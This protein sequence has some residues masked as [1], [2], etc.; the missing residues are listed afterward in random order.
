MERAKL[1]E[2]SALWPC[3]PTQPLFHYVG[4]HPSVT[5][6]RRGARGD[7]DWGGRL[8]VPA[9]VHGGKR[10]WQLTIPVMIIPLIHIDRTKPRSCT[11]VMVARFEFYEKCHGVWMRH[12]HSHPLGHDLSYMLRNFY[13]FTQK[14]KTC[15]CIHKTLV[16]IRTRKVTP[17]YELCYCTGWC[18]QSL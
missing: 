1:P 18:F 8:L 15:Q 7:L 9:F 10:N 2:Q 4:T 3:P 6:T 11:P 12:N 13:D 17:E 5:H 14:A 16:D